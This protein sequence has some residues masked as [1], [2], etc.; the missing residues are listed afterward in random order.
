MTQLKDK[1]TDASDCDTACGQLW[2]GAWFFAMH[3]CEYSKVYGNRCT[4][5]LHLENLQFI[6]DKKELTLNHPELHLVD[7]ISITFYFQKN[8]KR[9]TIV[10]QHRTHDPE[11]CAI[12]LWAAIAKRILA[13]P[14]TDH[15]TSVNTYMHRGKL[16][17]VSSKMML[18][19]VRAV[20]IHV[21]EDNLIFKASE[22]R[23]HSIRSGAA[24]AMYLANVPVFTIMLIGRWSSDTF[25]QYIRCQV[26]EFSSGVASRMITSSD[27]Y[28][29]PDFAHCDNP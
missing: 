19:R 8:D 5:L 15:K 26:H 20:V 21:G 17:E 24:M 1:D 25:L 14:G 9:D 13:Y 22:M 3:S 23:T 4:K 7:T 18:N 16:S 2:G 28:M 10:T 6:R 11:L 27:F 12:R 29:I